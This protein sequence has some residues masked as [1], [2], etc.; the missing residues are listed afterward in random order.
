MVGERGRA[1]GQRRVLRQWIGARP[2]ALAL[3]PDRRFEIVA[4]RGRERAFV[5]GRGLQL[6][7]RARLVAS[8]AVDRALERGGF[9][10]Q[11]GQG[12]A[13]G[14]ESSFGGGARIGGGLPFLIG[15]LDRGFC[16]IAVRL[17][18][19]LVRLRRSAL[20]FERSSVGQGGSIALKPR[21]FALGAIALVARGGER[22][23]GDAQLRLLGRLPGHGSRQLQLGVARLALRR[24]D[25]T[26]EVGAQFLRLGDSRLERRN[27]GGQPR[28][29]VGRVIGERAFPRAILLQPAGLLAQVGQAPNDRVAFGAQRGQPMARFIGGIAGRLGSGA[30]IGERGD[31]GLGMGGGG[32]LPFLRGGDGG[33][34]L[35][36]FGAGRFGAGVRFAPAGKQSAAFGNADLVGQANIAFG[37]LGLPPQGI[38][39]RIHVEQDF[40]EPSK[41]GFGRAQFLFGILA[42][43]MKAGDARRFLQHG[44]ALL[45][46]RGNDGGDPPLADQRRAVRTGR[47]VGEDQR[48]ILGPDILAIGAI[49]AARAALDPASDFQFAVGADLYRVEQFTLFLHGQ[50][51]HFGE[52]ALRSAG[53]AGEDDILHARAAHRFGAGFAHDPADRFQQVGLAAAIGADDAGQSRLDPQF[54]GVD[55]ALEAG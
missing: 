48:D 21:C 50:Q 7:E 49:G 8:A 32:R 18:L 30:A 14:G 17:R 12:G 23:F 44:A 45:R 41:I 33:V 35:A 20:R 22:G 15:R 6:V 39:T 24:C 27:F 40:V 38:G 29:G 16:G 55:E 13:R 37:R 34:G 26:G 1:G 53:G 10:V 52:V 51:R 54:G 11:R 47:G 43:D 42:P 46:A 2:A 31:G 25:T 19:G 28:N 4:Q 5:T 3:D 36:S 9:A